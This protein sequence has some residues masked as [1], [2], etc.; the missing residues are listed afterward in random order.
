MK[1]TESEPFCIFKELFRKY[2]AESKLILLEE[3]LGIGGPKELWFLES[4][5]TDED[6]RVR[7]RAAI[8]AKELKEI[9]DRE[10]ILLSKPEGV[11]ESGPELNEQGT[12][13]EKP[14]FNIEF[15]LL[16]R[17]EDTQDRQPASEALSSDTSGGETNHSP[18]MEK[19][20][21]MLKK[22]QA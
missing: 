1:P 22:N 21:T 9:L 10:S 14:L 11:P 16:E 4:L 13:I 3:I 12:D 7:K 19:L 6:R 15:D 17:F 8:L 20:L 18:L 2:D 5:V